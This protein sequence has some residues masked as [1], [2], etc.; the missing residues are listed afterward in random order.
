MHYPRRQKSRTNTYHYYYCYYCYCYCY[1][2][3]CY[4]CTTATT[5]V[6]S[7]ALFQW[8]DFPC[9]FRNRSAKMVRHLCDSFGPF[10]CMVPSKLFRNTATA[11]EVEG[12]HSFRQIS[13]APFFLPSSGDV[14]NI[15]RCPRMFWNVCS[16]YIS[17]ISVAICKF[18]LEAVQGVVLIRGWFSKISSHDLRGFLGSRGFLEILEL[19]VCSDLRGLFSKFHLVVLVVSSV[20]N[21]PH[22]PQQH[23]NTPKCLHAWSW[24]PIFWH[25]PLQKQKPKISRH[26]QVKIV[27][28]CVQLSEL[29]A[30]FASW[31]CKFQRDLCTNYGPNFSGQLKPFKWQLNP[32]HKSEQIHSPIRKY[33]QDKIFTDLFCW[34]SISSIFNL[35]V[36]RVCTCDPARRLERVLH[37]RNM[38]RPGLPQKIRE[39]LRWRN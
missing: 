1:C 17:Q 4:C 23:P 25:Q 37:R 30:M 21:E 7:L 36:W 34:V 13:V 2:Y 9:P 38:F 20:K 3:Y 35:A 29:C 39:R 22:P 8:R 5:S 15:F 27:A 11:T 14:Y 32:S 19:V 10:V 12:E 6:R 33:L 28:F 26:V 31:R 24:T 18:F 16:I